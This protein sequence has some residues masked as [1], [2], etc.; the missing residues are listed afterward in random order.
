MPPLGFGLIT[1]VSGSHDRAVDLEPDDIIVLYIDGLVERRDL[2]LDQRLSDLLVI[3]A[4]S[5]ALTPEELCNSLLEKLV[6][7]GVQGDDIAILVIAVDSPR[8]TDSHAVN[9]DLDA[10]AIR[11]TTARS[12]RVSFAL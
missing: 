4:A 10:V 9:L 6:G 8:R 5:A 3:A 7:G 11:E 2:P 12:R 1:H